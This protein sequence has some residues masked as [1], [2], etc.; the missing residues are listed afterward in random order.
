[1]TS[2][3]EKC[4]PKDE[5]ESS[6]DNIGLRLEECGCRVGVSLGTKIKSP[7]FGGGGR[8]LN[9]ESGSS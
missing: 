6:L 2:T 4:C 3:I 5:P 9:T 8:P 7:P 1:M